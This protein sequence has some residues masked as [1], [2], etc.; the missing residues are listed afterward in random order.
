MADPDQQ[1]D[2]H[3]AA[4]PLKAD[5]GRQL[6]IHCRAHHPGDIVDHHE[7][8]ERIQKKAKKRPPVGPSDISILWRYYVNK[9]KTFKE[10]LEQ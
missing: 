4:D 7:E 2:Q 1:E 3:L 10:L 6:V 5:L 8:H 9:K